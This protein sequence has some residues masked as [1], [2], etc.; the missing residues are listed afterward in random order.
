MNTVRSALLIMAGAL[1]TV[2][3]HGATDDAWPPSRDGIAFLWENGRSLNEARDPGTGETRQYT[4]L[5][6]GRAIYGPHY[7]LQLAG[8]S[9]RPSDVDGALLDACRR[10]NELT[11]EA[12]IAPDTLN[13][14]GPARIVTFSSDTGARNFTLGQSGDRLV[15]R[16]RTPRT[17][18]NGTNP[19]F[20]LCDVRV[21]VPQHVLVSCRPGRLRAYR[22]G[23]R[24]FASDEDWGDFSNWGPQQLVFGDEV[25]GQRDWAGSLEGVAIYSQFVPER[26]ARE[27]YGS[28]A[29]RLEDR[30]APPR[31]VVEATLVEAASRP[32]PKRLGTYRRALVEHLYA[33][34]RAVSG[35]VDDGRI[36]VAHWAVLDRAAI[37]E[38]RHPGRSYRLTIEP[39]ESHP[40]LGSEWIENYLDESNP[41]VFYDVG[42]SVDELPRTLLRINAGGPDIGRRGTDGYWAS[43]REYARGGASYPFDKRH[44]LSKAANPAP[45]EVYHTVRHQEHRYDFP[46]LPNGAYTVRFHFTDGHTSYRRAMDYIAEGAR[47]IDNLNISAAAGA[48]WRALT[49]DAYVEVADG[50]GMQIECKQDRG[51]D[52]FEAGIEILTAVGDAP[53]AAARTPTR[54]PASDEVPDDLAWL[55]GLCGDG[56]LAYQ[57]EGAVRLTELSTGE[58]ETLGAGRKPEFSPDSSKLVWLDGDTVRGRMRRGDT[59]TRT[60]IRDVDT[61]AGVHWFDDRTLLVVLRDGSGKRGWHKVALDGRRERVPVLD[62]LGL[63]GTETDVKRAD[64]GVWSYVAN[65]NWKTSDGR[66]GHIGGGCSCSLSPDARSITALQGSHR[67]V[68]LN[69]IRPGGYARVVQWRY[70]GKFDNHRWSS[71]DPRFV[72]ATEE[73]R[74]LIVVISREDGR[75][76]R[77]GMEHGGGELYGDFTTG[78]GRGDPW[79]TTTR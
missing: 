59:E 26:E 51:V 46:E 14:T 21:G 2:G 8:G 45:Q 78:D 20:T 47:V 55:R 27:H 34:T 33:V 65:R 48:T 36:V 29:A 39:W 79:P 15:L 3:A 61:S 11:V 76:T 60:L 50:N 24:V 6:H 66:D 4:G 22:D 16:V 25:G 40:Q 10:S 31:T 75:A 37:P 23:E 58:T 13:Q 64:D 42:R 56:A 19:E 62:G 30:V 71:N 68:H 49:I 17:G 70:A 7:E 35:G 72:V 5:L 74:G 54:S 67:E 77:M 57:A 44:D 1:L 32:D 18:G 53:A 63:G 52:V 41:P 73:T 28:Y 9:F 43:D 69:A 12:V 38:R